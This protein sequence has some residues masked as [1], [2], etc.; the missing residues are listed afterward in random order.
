MNLLFTCSDNVKYIGSWL[1][2]ISERPLCLLSSLCPL[3][4]P[5]EWSCHLLLPQILEFRL[6]WAPGGLQKSVFPFPVDSISLPNRLF[7]PFPTLKT[8][9]C[10]TP[11]SGDL[12]F[13]SLEKSESL[14][15]NAFSFLP[16]HIK[17]SLYPHLPFNS[18]PPYISK[19]NI[20]PSF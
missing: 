11:V 14:T 13:Y 6:S 1:E 20:L 15:K 19:K 18:S 5:H 4:T 9:T 3:R 7:D 12:T 16:P 17:M 8:N 10:P 2:Y